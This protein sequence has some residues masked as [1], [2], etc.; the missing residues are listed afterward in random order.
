MNEKT[1]RILCSLGLIGFSSMVTFC[2]TYPLG[3]RRGLRNDILDIKPIDK[4]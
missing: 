1:F 2:I 3:L 4:K